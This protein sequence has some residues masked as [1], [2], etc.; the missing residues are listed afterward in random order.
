[1][2]FTMGLKVSPR[3]Y[4]IPVIMRHVLLFADIV[5]LSLFFDRILPHAFS[6]YIEFF[7]YATLVF[8]VNDINNFR[9]NLV[10][11]ELFINFAPQKVQYE[12]KSILS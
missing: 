6:S 11:S 9:I 7:G 8:I 10:A 1:M 2:L 12:A 3:K 5:I 4:F